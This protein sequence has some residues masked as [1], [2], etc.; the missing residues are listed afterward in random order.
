MRATRLTGGVSART[1]AQMRAR[2]TGLEPPGGLCAC[3]LVCVERCQTPFPEYRCFLEKTLPTPAIAR[4]CLLACARTPEEINTIE[5]TEMPTGE[6]IAFLERGPFRLRVRYIMRPQ[7]PKAGRVLWGVRARGQWEYW[8]APAALDVS[9]LLAS[10][11]QPPQFDQTL[12]FEMELLGDMWGV[13]SAEY[14]GQ[15]IE[16]YR[17]D[18]TI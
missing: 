13:G 18:C 9:P 4:K 17:L 10:T 1:L 8:L 12:H 11:I 7:R 5:R 14:H 15:A 2:R 6:P 3:Y 16:F